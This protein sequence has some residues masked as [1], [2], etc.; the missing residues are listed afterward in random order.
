VSFF[1]VINHTILFIYI[2]YLY[3]YII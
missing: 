3:L 1:I 2:K